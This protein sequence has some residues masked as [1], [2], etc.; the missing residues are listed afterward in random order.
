MQLPVAVKAW[1]T[2]VRTP[3]LSLSVVLVSI[4]GALAYHDGVFN[5]TRFLFCMI[6]VVSAHSAVNL[7]NEYS[8]DKTRIDHHTRRT[9]FSGGSGTIQAGLI[10]PAAVLAAAVVTLCA[11]GAIGTYLAFVSGWAVSALMAFGVVTVVT[12]T[13]HLAKWGLG[14]TAAGVGL[15]SLVIVGTY[16]TQSGWITAEAAWISVSPGIL[17]ALLLFLNEFPDAP[18][19][20]AGGRKHLVILLGYKR[21]AIL[22]CAALTLAYGIVVAGVAA[23]VVPRTLLLSLLTIPLAVK[24][25][26]TAVRHGSLFEKMVP[27]LGA[28]VG[29]V[30]GTD[31]LIAVAYMV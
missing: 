5:M 19:D 21:A 13:T 10:T 15:G 24:A 4:G 31:V 8:D 25:A 3:F 27:A 20:R 17:T 29:V 7:F 14:E 2:Q 23:N 30:L 26:V 16:Y 12:Y 18:A 22:Y 9:P 11:A 28:N 1:I 6:G